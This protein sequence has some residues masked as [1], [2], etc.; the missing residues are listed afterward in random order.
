MSTKK[1]ETTPG[2]GQDGISVA[3]P[4]AAYEQALV[5]FGE[6]VK[7]LGQGDYAGAK[8]VF[9][10]VVGADE[11]E[12]ELTQRARSYAAICAGRLAPPI[13]AP[14][15]MEE[16]YARAVFLSNSG[17]WDEA[18]SLL[19]QSLVEEPNSIRCLYAR[20]CV[21]ALK[22]STSRAVSDLRQAIASEPTVRFQAVNDPDFEKIRE[23]PS[24]IDVIEPTPSGA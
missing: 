11:N 4:S 8:A 15:T 6:A 2:S 12:P 22:G 24:F 17:A 9:L 18:L 13:P 14:A 16:R 1:K 19:D 7:L 10:E 23:E 3:P 21:W 5:K 20:A